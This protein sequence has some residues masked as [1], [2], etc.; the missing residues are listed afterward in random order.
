MFGTLGTFGFR[1]ILRPKSLERMEKRV[2]NWCFTFNNY[3][4]ENIE[5]LAQ[6]F[7]DKSEYVFQEEVGENGTPHLQGFVSF[8]NAQR[9]SFQENLPKQIHWETCKGNKKNNINYCTKKETRNGRIFSNFYEELKDEFKYNIIT[10]WQREILELIKTEP[11]NRT[12]NWYY[13]ETGNIGKTILARHIAIE[14]ERCIVVSGKANDIKFAIAGM[15]NKPRIVIWDIPR[16]NTDYISY[17][18]LEEVKNGM[19]FNG[20]YESGMTIFNPP[21]VI[22]FANV[23]PEISKLSLDRWNIKKI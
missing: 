6:Y 23:E 7:S 8:K 4:E 5:N 15:E 21:H 19:F 13:N 12:I 16:C 2:R 1:V 11:D 9:I 14:N 22:V 3:T 17:S 10:D 20:K 18:A